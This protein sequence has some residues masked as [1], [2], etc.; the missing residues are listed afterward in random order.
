MGERGKEEEKAIKEGKRGV[1]PVGGMAKWQSVAASPN[2][3]SEIA[4]FFLLLLL[5]ASGASIPFHL[6]AVSGAA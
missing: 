4:D 3:L 5:T 2:P 1:G 6:S